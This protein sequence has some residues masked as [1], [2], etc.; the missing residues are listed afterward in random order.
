[1]PILN[2][3]KKTVWLLA[4]VF[5]GKKMHL[6]CI[7][8]RIKHFQ[9][10]SRIKPCFDTTSDDDRVIEVL[11]FAVEKKPRLFRN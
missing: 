11:T 9:V 1:M 5:P 4:L 8:D 3:F 10:V 6:L 2:F 7:F